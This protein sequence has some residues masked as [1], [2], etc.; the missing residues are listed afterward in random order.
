LAKCSDLVLFIYHSLWNATLSYTLFGTEP[1]DTFQSLLEDGSKFR[2]MA[3]TK[4]K[5]K[6]SAERKS[7]KKAAPATS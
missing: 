3:K 2:D 1:I 4:A 7:A 6:A 5:K